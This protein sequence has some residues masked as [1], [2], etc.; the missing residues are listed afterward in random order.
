M[1]VLSRAGDVLTI[2]HTYLDDTL[3]EQ[4]LVLE[5]FLTRVDE[6]GILPYDC[7]EADYDWFLELNNNTPE[8]R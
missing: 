4:P 8:D 1:E 2:T 7:M 5:Y 6:T 3:F